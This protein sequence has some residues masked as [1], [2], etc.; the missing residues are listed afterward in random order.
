MDSCPEQ[1]MTPY[2]L[3]QAD[4]DYF[5]SVFQV[6]NRFAE[7]DPFQQDEAF[8]RITT[9][10]PA[11]PSVIQPIRQQFFHQQ[12]IPISPPLDTIVISSDDKAPV[13]PHPPQSETVDVPPEAPVQQR[14][15]TDWRTT[16][17]SWDY[18][19]FFRNRQAPPSKGV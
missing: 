19:K 14:P 10:P 7:R 6:K 16:D 12:Q 15:T 13:E 2:Q 17:T 8:R 11:Q 1:Q 4:E 9:S 18:N 3:D 5:S